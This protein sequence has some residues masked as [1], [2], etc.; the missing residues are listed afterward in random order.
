MSWGHQELPPFLYLASRKKAKMLANNVHNERKHSRTCHRFRPSHAIIFNASVG[1]LR[2]TTSFTYP[3]TNPT[4]YGAVFSLH[5]LYLHTYFDDAHTHYTITHINPPH[6]S[7]S[8][9]SP[10][11]PVS[12]PVSPVFSFVAAGGDFPASIRLA[13]Y[14]MARMT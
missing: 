5:Y 12:T 2:P 11:L 13:R 4:T 6:E 8:S 1:Y 7:K 10:S 3:I 14:R 9:L